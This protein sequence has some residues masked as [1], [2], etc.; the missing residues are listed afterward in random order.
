MDPEGVGLLWPSKLS[1]R[2]TPAGSFRV[3]GYEHH[4]TFLCLADIKD[5]PTPMSSETA[6][7]Q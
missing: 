1:F 5:I 4:D 3:P 6:C 7:N 2:L